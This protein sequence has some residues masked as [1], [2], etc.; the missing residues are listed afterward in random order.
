MYIVTEFTVWHVF[1]LLCPGMFDIT[2]PAGAVFSMSLH[3]SVR[4]SKTELHCHWWKFAAVFCFY[5]FS[6]CS[7]LLILQMNE[8]RMS[9]SIDNCC[10]VLA[11]WIDLL[12]PYLCGLGFCWYDIF[13]DIPGRF[14]IL[15]PRS[16]PAQLKSLFLFILWWAYFC[17]PG[18]ETK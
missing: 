1:F 9:L 16:V 2:S 6:F 11:L 3:P 7:R 10:Y 14:G 18:A 13:W 5:R 15:Y 8:E 4:C 17:L 12:L